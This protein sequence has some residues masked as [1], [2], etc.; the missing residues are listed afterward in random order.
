MLSSSTAAPTKAPTGSRLYGPLST[1]TCSSL[2]SCSR[3]GPRCAEPFISLISVLPLPPLYTPALANP[4]QVDLQE[5][6]NQAHNKYTA[7]HWAA[8]KGHL[9]M[10][11][12]LIERG[13][14]LDI[15]DKH[16]NSPLMLAEKKLAVERSGTAHLKQ[17]RIFL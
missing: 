16:S 12:L 17:V 3:R 10:A 8:Q 1:I 2:L 5:P 9:E 13:A 15:R 4:S 11:T 14:K 7:L 6:E